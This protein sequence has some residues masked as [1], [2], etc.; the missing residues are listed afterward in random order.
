[1]SRTFA[2]PNAGLARPL[3]LVLFLGAGLLA[4]PRPVLPQELETNP[5][6]VREPGQKITPETRAQERE[7][8]RRIQDQQIQ[9]RTIQRNAIQRQQFENDRSAA[10]QREN[11][12]QQQLDR[13]RLDIL[14]NR[15]KP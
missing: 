3:L 15:D 1:M 7:V 10:Q 12:V 4:A 2:A 6:P 11:A 9:E 5:N 8:N 13:Q 14:N